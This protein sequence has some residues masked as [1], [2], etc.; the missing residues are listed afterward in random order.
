MLAVLSFALGF[1]A[2]V[3]AKER[4]CPP[5]PAPAAQPAP[6]PVDGKDLGAAKDTVG[7]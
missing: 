7:K 6:A 5:V 1:G 3:M 2:G 4:G